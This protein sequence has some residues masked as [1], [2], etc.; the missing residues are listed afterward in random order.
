MVC[1]EC[2]VLFTQDAVAHLSRLGVIGEDVGGLVGG[3]EGG[4]G[5][6]GGVQGGDSSEG[7][8][9]MAEGSTSAQDFS[10]IDEVSHVSQ[11]VKST[12]G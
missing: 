7:V 11:Y 4:V 3:S 12:T 1:Y 9:D 2:V 5:G 10:E 6:E 8:G